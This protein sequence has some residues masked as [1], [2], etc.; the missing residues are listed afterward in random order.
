MIGE[1]WALELILYSNMFKYIMV[2]IYVQYACMYAYAANQADE[3]Y[4]K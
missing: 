2:L 1:Q 3:P 4:Q